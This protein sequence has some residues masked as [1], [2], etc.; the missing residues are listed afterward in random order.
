MTSL[1]FLLL[2]VAPN[3]AFVLG[4]QLLNGFNHLLLTV[5]GVTYADEQA[6]KGY[7]ATAQG[8]F[9]MA[10]GGIGA[11]V[12]GFVGGLLFEG[13]GAKGMYWVF[14]FFVLVILVFKSIVRRTFPPELEKEPLPQASR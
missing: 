7:R 9:T 11:A 12:G 3:P 14:C 5:A 4:V 10:L 2:A 8:L 1:R 13:V 6:P